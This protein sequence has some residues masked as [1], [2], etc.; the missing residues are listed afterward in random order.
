MRAGL[1]H[2]SLNSRGGGERVAVNVIELLNEMGFEVELITSQPPDFKQLNSAY[3]RDVRVNKVRSLLPIKISVFGIYQRLFTSIPAA[4][5][6]VDILVNTHGDV[7]PHISSNNIP[8]ITYCHFP[9]VALLLKDYPSKYQNSLFWRIYFEPYRR[10]MQGR[11]SK[12]ICT[13]VVLTNSEF[14]KKAIIDLYPKANPVIISPPVDTKSFR[15]ILNS[16]RRENQVLVVSRFTSEK[17]LELALEVAK[18]L[19]VKVV[20]IGS[21]IPANKLYFD[22]LED[23][24]QKESL[25]N[26]VT[27]L[28]NASFSTLLDTMSKSKVYLHT[29]RGEH[30]GISIVEAMSAG[31]IPVVPDYGGFT[32]FVPRQY[33][34]ND[35]Y[36]MID[37]IQYAF[38]LAY[39]ERDKISNIADQ[40]SEQNFKSKMKKLIEEECIA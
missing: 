33:H 21:L 26:L 9:S 24:I 15:Q 32:E 40:F 7:L 5:S 22:M 36:K 23:K 3:N 18:K 27:L 31:L 19:K 17:R 11:M 30:F 34:Y 4:S 12:S 16:S 13:G 8:T 6:K 37:N 25:Q 38:D 2:H 10:I 29:M 39:S 1:V 20:I 28:P 14:S 35:I